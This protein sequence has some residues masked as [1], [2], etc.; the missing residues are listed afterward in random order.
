MGK[1]AQMKQE[2]WDYLSK[3]TDHHEAIVLHMYNNRAS[4][5]AKQDVTCGVGFFLN[6]PED[7][8]NSY[9]DLFFDPDT[10][11]PATDDQIRADWKAASELLR[12]GWPNSNLESTADGQ[13]YADVCKLRMNRDK[14]IAKRNDILGSK[15]ET[16]LK[17]VPELGQFYDYPAQAQ[18]AIAS[19]CYGFTPKKAVNMVM[20]LF[21][22]NFDG[23][24]RES[25]LSGMSS[26]KV[27]HHRN[28][29]WNAARICEQKLDYNLL[30]LSPNK[31][32]RIPWKAC[33]NTYGVVVDKEPAAPTDNK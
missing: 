3:F 12:T 32:E 29:F 30:P 23:A 18:V 17:D 24:G 22:W 19:F 15:L 25:F 26:I 2:T 31:P 13:G 1:P 14:V 28:L 10:K 20:E 7:A 4:A 21:H 27:L 6:S 33:T 8:I 9:K 11:Q 16:A 5:Q